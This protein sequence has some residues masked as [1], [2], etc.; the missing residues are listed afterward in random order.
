MLNEQLFSKELRE[1]EDTLILSAVAI[2]NFAHT[3]N[4]LSVFKAGC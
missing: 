3:Q 1:L 4:R 2:A